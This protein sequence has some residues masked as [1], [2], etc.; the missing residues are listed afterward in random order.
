[1]AVG[2]LFQQGATAAPV[3]VPG[4]GE[5]SWEAVSG[6]NVTDP[7]ISGP[8]MGSNMPNDVGSHS[9]AF[10][11]LPP[12]DGGYAAQP[13]GTDNWRDL[14]DFQ[15]SPAPWV[16]LIAFAAIGWVAFGA[17]ARLGP[18]KAAASVGR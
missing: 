3:D 18:V 8:G 6:I 14:L 13:K 12:A 1:M 9:G 5:M 17:S 11:S 15:G 2:V 10:V 4:T 16:L 7:L